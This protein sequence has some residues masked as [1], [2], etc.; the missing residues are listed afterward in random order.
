MKLKHLILILAGSASLT[1]A[2]TTVTFHKDVEPLLQKHC[3]TCHHPGD[4]APM[5]FMSY[6]DAR[7]WAKAIK[8]AVAT[9]KMPPWFADPK[10]GSFL[11]DTSLAQND[12]DTLIAWADS[13][14]KEG[15]P[16]DAPKPLDFST[17]W[18]IGKPDAIVKVPK[19][20]KVPASGTVPYQ[21]IRIPTG[22]TEDKWV[23]AIEVRPSNRAV[24]HH[25]NASTLSPNGARSN[26]LKPGEYYALDIE[27][28]NRAL[29]AQGK[30]PPMFGRTGDDELLEVF[31]PGTVAKPL[32]TGQARLIHA[33]SDIMLQLHYTATTGK[34][35]E[36]WAS[37]G[38]KFTNEPPVERIRGALVLNAHFTIPAKSSDH[39]VEARA[40]ILNDTKL[41]AMLP[42]MHV[43][44]K[45]FEY[46]AIYPTGETET[47]LKV[48]K[49]DFHW[50]LNY[51]LKE[52]KLLPKGTIIECIAH[53]DNSAN[54][55][56]NPNPNVDV[57]YGEQTWEEM[58]N[59]FMEVSI[60]PKAKIQ[61]V[62]GPAPPKDA[63][64]TAASAPAAKPAAAN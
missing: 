8:T 54:N 63:V 6:K 56:D 39:R 5:S 23:T 38:F 19:P 55:P 17:G 37:V 51:Y 61:Q 14:T 20:F 9:K 27:A 16:K 62:F 53:F 34:P 59:G 45:D 50:Q 30:E 1:S 21:Y 57:H 18:Y 46:R 29:I 15:D 40:T 11:N 12:I 13:G 7:P 33:G 3:Q 60:D 58:V 31:V 64:K 24:V 44:G 41:V 47:L 52:P 49:Y 28:G 43:R 2:A 32:K 22:F 10:H 35:E 36:D 25:I 42:H 4:I 48:S 26:S